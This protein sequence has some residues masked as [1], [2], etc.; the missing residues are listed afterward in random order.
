M[1][2]NTR[3]GLNAP[4]VTV[5]MAV[6]NGQ[7]HVR[8]AVEG[9][10]GQTFPDFEFIIVDD[11]S[12]DG[13]SR[14]L[15]EFS[16]PRI[17][18]LKHESNLGLIAALNTGLAAAR[19]EFIARQDVDDFSFP[20]RL[21]TQVDFLRSRP[22]VAVVGSDTIFEPVAGST[23]TTRTVERDP[24]RLAW[25]LLFYCPLAHSSIVFRRKVIQDL[26]GYCEADVFAEDFALWARVA[27]SNQV[28]SVGPVLVIRR[29]PPE[30]I[31]ERYHSDM[32]RAARR[33]SLLN[34]EWVAGA[35]V[36]AA[37]LDAIQA[38]F[39]NRPLA[40]S[41]A[42]ALDFRKLRPAVN[43]VFEEFWA[44]LGG[45]PATL[46]EF[47]KWAFRWMGRAL[48]RRIERLLTESAAHDG[49]HRLLAVRMSRALVLSA[50]RMSPAVISRPGGVRVAL[51][52]FVL[53][54]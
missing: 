44:R 25:I 32:G 11:G 39:G 27:R 42:L 23:Q 54:A 40:L 16:D 20:E 38:F 45:E 36:S 33:V 17:V 35:S 50:I 14:V 5:L 7:S 37:R 9:I 15:D 24:L 34:L 51:R 47:R 4:V 8:Q 26:G 43:R 28:A 18:R 21:R 52:A 3:E 48:L 19:G 53:R 46:P 49:Q 6:Y 41:E 2:G 31:T 13:T 22:D 30:S 10:L 29:R 12:T 1:I